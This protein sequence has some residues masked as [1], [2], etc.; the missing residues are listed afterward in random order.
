M[1]YNVSMMWPIKIWSIKILG[2]YLGARLYFEIS[3]TLLNINNQE[4]DDPYTTIEAFNEFF[5]SFADKIQQTLTKPV[6]EFHYK[7]T[8]PDPYCPPFILTH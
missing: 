6:S 7:P 5:C 2:N 4:I 1:I 3:F 8:Q